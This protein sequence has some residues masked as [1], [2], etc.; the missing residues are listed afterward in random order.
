MGQS[1]DGF[2]EVEVW[3]GKMTP[4]KVQL[5]DRCSWRCCGR[6]SFL[7]GLILVNIKRLSLFFKTTFIILSYLTLLSMIRYYITLISSSCLAIDS[8]NPQDLTPPLLLDVT[9]LLSWFQVSMWRRWIDANRRFLDAQMDVLADVLRGEKYAD[10][11]KRKMFKSSNHILFFV[12][13]K[14]WMKRVKIWWSWWSIIT[15]RWWTV[16]ALWFK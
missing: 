1:I 14:L 10:L 5:G 6:E 4:P 11:L 7:L 15:I 9:T 16:D 13:R 12:E 2:V 8:Y 3:K